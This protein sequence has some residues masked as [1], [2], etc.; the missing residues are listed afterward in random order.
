M[1][2]L[3]AVAVL[4]SGCQKLLD[5]GTV[6]AAD[7]RLEQ[8]DAPIDHAIDAPACA[9]NPNVVSDDFT[10]PACAAWGTAYHQGISS[11][12]QSAGELVVTMGAGTTE[13]YGG[14]YSNGTVPLDAVGVFVG[15]DRVDSAP[16]AW[17]EL[18]LKTDD[19]HAVQI[20]VTDSG[21][22][23]TLNDYGD[24]VRYA[25]TAYLPARMKYVR[26]HTDAALT[27]V[28]G[29]YSADAIT[30]TPVGDTGAQVT[31]VPVVVVL[32]S[33]DVDGT[34]GSAAFSHLNVCP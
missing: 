4:V 28:I 15:I 12:L 34:A 23:L 29:E 30:W 33:G 25:T 11:V 21:T 16:N 24:S 22:V 10:G 13:Q 9:P 20:G 19:S 17:T 27:T 14:C 18:A 32:E 3:L 26:L 5:L 6:S 1:R 7:A 8:P 2:A 31:P